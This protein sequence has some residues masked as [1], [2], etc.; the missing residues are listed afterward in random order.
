MN[1]V[2]VCSQTV[3]PTTG[4]YSVR[5]AT[6][7]EFQA[8]RIPWNRLVT[9]MQFPSPFCTWEWVFT[10]WQQFGS[11][12]ELLPLFVCDGHD[13]RGILPLF[14]PRSNANGH[15][16]T[17]DTLEYCGI[18]HVY[19]DHLD[20][21]SAPEDVPACL[22]AAIDFIGSQV[23]RWTQV[24][25]P[26]LVQNSEL[27]HA[28]PVVLGKLHMAVRQVSVAPFLELTGSFEDYLARLPKKDRYKIKS[29]RKKYLEDGKL[30]YEA[31]GSSEFD[32][33]LHALFE[34][35]ARRADAKGITST[36]ERPAVFEF[37]RALLRLLN[38][39][40]VLLRCLKDEARVIAV[41]YGFRC[42]GR[43]FFYQI[44]YDPD[45]SW[46]SPGVLL[47]SE[48]IRE[49]FATGCTEFNFLQGDDAYKHTFTRK[50]RALFDCYLYNATFSGRLAR[51]AFGLRERLKAAVR[52]GAAS[53]R[54]TPPE[55]P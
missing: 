14:R 50:A 8:S 1:S 20:F 47:V 25:L 3:S 10:W 55:A 51:R 48:A 52:G 19:P 12:Q 21:I 33:A 39:D 11:D 4:K 15:W 40:D 2:T 22:K 9:S 26:M 54:S 41:L 30:Q 6:L 37:H 31:F 7:E 45:C 28:L 5:L 27:L 34:L 29:P 13:V 43:V 38:P 46:A 49:A 32:T 36:F 53:Q 17:R 24:R 35:H 44:G 23:P 16:F 42:G 18:T